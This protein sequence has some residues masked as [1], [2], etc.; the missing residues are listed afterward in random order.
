MRRR[1]RATVFRGTSPRR[2]TLH[3]QG[4]R[5]RKGEHRG[6]IS[7]TAPPV[8]AAGG[9]SGG[10]CH[11]AG[12]ALARCREKPHGTAVPVDPGELAAAA[13]PR[14]GS[15]GAAHHFTTG[16]R[17]IRYASGSAS[18]AEA[19]AGT[20]VVHQVELHV[21][22]ALEQQALA[23]GLVVRRVLAPRDDA[24]VHLEEAP[25]RPRARRRSRTP[26]RRSPGRRRRSRRRR[27]APGD[28]AGRSSGR[29]TP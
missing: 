15:C 16:G 28:A 19:E 7:Q 12:R 11:G 25:R 6:D 2:A 5:E 4:H 9:D 29:T 20:A 14:S 22:A 13:D 21:T 26:H 17:L 1:S 8:A 27:A 18:V 3:I 23:R 24:R 10:H